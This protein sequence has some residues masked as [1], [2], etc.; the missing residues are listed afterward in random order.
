DGNTVYEG[1]LSDFYHIGTLDHALD[2]Y[3]ENVYSFEELPAAQ[4]H[5]WESGFGRRFPRGLSPERLPGR[6]QK[7]Y[8]Y[9]F[10]RR[11]TVKCYL[12]TSLLPDGRLYIGAIYADYNNGHAVAAVL[13]RL[14]ADM[15]KSGRYEQYMLAAAT[16]S[17]L[18]LSEHVIKMVNAGHTRHM[19]HN[20]Y[21]KF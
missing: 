19:I 16:R 1:K 15:E 5:N 21:L 9:I 17:G 11:N 8:S 10:I 18:R 13:G 7:R 14:L 2:R 4:L 12:L 6:W 3:S 20:F